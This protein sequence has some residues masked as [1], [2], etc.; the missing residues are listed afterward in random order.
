MN[1]KIIGRHLNR[2]RSHYKLML[3]NMCNSLIKYEKIKTTLQKAKELRRVIEKIINISKKNCLHNKRI[4]FSK[5]RNMENTKKTINVFG[6]Y[7]SNINGGYTKIIK[8]YK[9]RNGDNANMVY[10]IINIKK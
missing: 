1:H 5:I 7:F 8:Y 4:I 6:K 2:T 10:I 3:R 9:F